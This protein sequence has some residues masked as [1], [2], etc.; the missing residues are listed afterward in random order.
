MEKSRLEVL[1]QFLTRNPK[2][3][4]ARYGV[5]MEYVRLG[6]AEKAIEQFRELWTLNPDYTA[7]YF[8]AGKLLAKTG[9]RELARQV[10]SEGVQSAARTGNLHAQSEIEAELAQL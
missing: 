3:A 10:L 4:F 8:Q 2:D 7:A 1:Q 9:Q 5:A 6:E